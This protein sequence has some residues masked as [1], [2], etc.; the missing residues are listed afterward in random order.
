MILRLIPILMVLTPS[1]WSNPVCEKLDLPASCKPRIENLCNEFKTCV[2]QYG[3]RPACAIGAAGVFHVTTCTTCEKQKSSLDSQIKLC[4]DS[5]NAVPAIPAGCDMHPDHKSKYVAYAFWG[6]CNPEQK[7]CQC[8]YT[9]C[10]GGEWVAHNK[11]WAKKP[12]KDGAGKI[13]SHYCT[14]QSCG[15]GAT[16]TIEC[17]VY[18]K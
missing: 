4:Q 7:N 11:Y 18:P 6:P 12:Y 15:N 3:N 10:T 2:N 8:S 14:S 5:A 16:G 1:A 17:Y 9:S 13:G